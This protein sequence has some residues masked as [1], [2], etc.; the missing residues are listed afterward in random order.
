MEFVRAHVYIKG[1]VQGV[2]YRDWTS[3]QAHDLGLTGWVRNMED[4]RVEA[5]FEGPK[6]KVNEMI[7]KCNEGTKLAKVA[8]IDV[9]W[10]DTTGEFEGFNVMH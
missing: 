6:K 2:F 9:I 4:G 10:E 8:H 7:E 5:I 3:K 1:R